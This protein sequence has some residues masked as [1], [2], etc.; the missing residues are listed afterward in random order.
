MTQKKI[1]IC[2]DEIHP[3]PP[4][5]NYTTKKTDV[6]HLDDNWSLGILGLKDYGPEI[7]RGYRCNIVVI[8]NFSKYGWTVPL[9]NKNSQTIKA[10]FENILTTSERKPNL[11]KTDR[12]KDLDNNIFQNFPSNNNIKQNFRNTSLEVVFA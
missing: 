11:I 5:R 9:K 6:Y 8:A 7:N 4:K 10:F 1:K 12:G 2:I 3:K